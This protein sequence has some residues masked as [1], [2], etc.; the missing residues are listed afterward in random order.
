ALACFDMQGFATR[1][2]AELSYGQMRRVLFARAWAGKP[3]LLL[4]DEPYSGLDARTRHALMGHLDELVAVGTT[5]VIA[6][7]NRE[8]WPSA[9]T[10]EL[11]LSQGSPVWCGPIR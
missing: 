11:A 6:T 1:H 5:L 10:H 8:E 2:L 9:A 3:V 4:L 7:H